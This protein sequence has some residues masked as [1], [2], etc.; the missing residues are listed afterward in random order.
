MP[1]IEINKKDLEKILNK[2]FDESQLEDLMQYTKAGIEKIEGD[3][4]TLEIKDSNR[5]DMLSVEGI[6]RELLGVTGK[7][8]GLAIYKAA[9]SNYEV[10]IDKKVSK[11][12]PE[13]VCAV[14]KD[15]KLDDYGIKQLIQLQ[16][17]LCEGFGRKRKDAA[18]GI[19]DFDKIKWP[20]RYTTFKSDEI[21]FVPLEMSQALSPRQI[22]Q[23][24]EKGKD[25]A[26]LLEGIED[27]PFIIDSEKNVLS[28]PPIINS[29]YTGKVT[30]HTKNV[31]VEVT[32]F[33]FDRIS[34]T[35]NII[36]AALAD[37]KG[38]IYSVSLK[39]KCIT[40]VFR[41]KKKN[42]ALSDIS[43]RLG[44]ELKPAEIVKILEK[45]RYL[46]KIKKDKV[47][48][49]IPFYRTD[50]IHAVDIIEDIAIAYGY[51][52]IPAEEPMI[53][54]IGSLLPETLK[55]EKIAKILVGLGLNE[56]AT[57]N[58]TNKEDLF[59]KM[60]L[61]TNGIIEIENPVSLT[62]SC[63]RNALIPSLMAVFSQ[64]TTSDYPQKI[65]EI[66]QAVSVNE[67]SENKADEKTKLAI[68]VSHSSAGFTEIKQVIDYLMA[69][70]KLKFK[71]NSTQNSSF[72]DGRTAELIIN[73]KPVGIFGEIHPKVLE[74]WNLEMPVAAAEIDLTELMKL[75]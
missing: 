6:G 66:G 29:D 9:K 75:F 13:I 34:Q 37:R 49:E 50:V 41:N 5:P 3:I 35:L 33:N 45:A 17:K 24:N 43:S 48:V 23:M 38:R 28:M 7:E 44:I 58:M 55:T 27:Y 10:I 69:S 62:Y 14:V 32:G 31:F 30:E 61:N 64:N 1:I 59:K 36:L 39:N 21:K 42:I 18:I 52:K 53:A 60:N 4:I 71:I 19:Y 12:R 73:N 11:V 40:P 57:F 47:E 54:T 51:Q 26:S 68:A 20:V 70:L 67:K 8:R 46:A 25:Y 56:L 74:S 2:K 22:L 63:L 65:F 72:I 16:E 15:L